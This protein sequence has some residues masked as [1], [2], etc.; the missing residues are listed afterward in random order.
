MNSTH[1]SVVASK[2]KGLFTKSK[3]KTDIHSEFESRYPCETCRGERMAIIESC[4]CDW[5]VAP[6][7][8]STGQYICPGATIKAERVRHVKVPTGFLR[9]A[10]RALRSTGNVY[11]A[12][13]LE[14]AMTVREGK[15]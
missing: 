8:I 1:I 2:V 4:M 12:T 3:H 9:L 7:R 6:H 15:E 14:D 10:I 13:A 5:V 11:A